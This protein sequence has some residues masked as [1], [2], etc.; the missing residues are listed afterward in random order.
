LFR[1]AQEALRNVVKHSA[2]TD[3]R[4]TLW[5]ANGMLELDIADSGR[6]FSPEQSGD[7]G[8]GLLSMRERVQFLGGDISVQ[9]SAGHGTRIEARVPI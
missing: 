2:A 4:V 8:L 7:A 5:H 3:A 6:G 9:S 1:V